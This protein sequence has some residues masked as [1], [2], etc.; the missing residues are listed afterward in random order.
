MHFSKQAHFFWGAEGTE[1]H[2]RLRGKKILIW[3]GEN[4][5]Q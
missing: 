2:L 5:E 1:E 4:I 3:M